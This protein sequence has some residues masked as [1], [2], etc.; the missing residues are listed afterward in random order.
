MVHPGGGAQG[1]T[2]GGR[3]QHRTPAPAAAPLRSL[4][5]PARI[6]HISSMFQRQRRCDREPCLPRFDPVV[7]ILAH[8]PNNVG[9]R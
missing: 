9:T 3:P 2:H 7:G 8:S 5:H 1:E 4:A 6:A